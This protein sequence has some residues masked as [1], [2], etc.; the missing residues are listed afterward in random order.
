[1]SAFEE[2]KA[3]VQILD[4]LAFYG[5][6]MCHASKA[7]CPLHNEKPP[8]FTVYPKSNSRYFGSEL[9]AAQMTATLV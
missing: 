2:L 9:F 7:I 8:N 3:R 4:V 5:V 6:E 1:M